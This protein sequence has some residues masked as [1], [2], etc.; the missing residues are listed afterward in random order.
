MVQSVE[1]IFPKVT[2]T[3]V[4]ADSKIDTIRK[5]LN[6]REIALVGKPSASDQALIEANNVKG[7]SNGDLISSITGAGKASTQSST[8]FWNSL[9][10]AIK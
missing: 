5:L 2:D 6:D 3:K 10:P 4:F 1:Q 9:T 7:K 8:D